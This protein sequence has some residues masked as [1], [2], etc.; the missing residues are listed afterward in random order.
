MRTLLSTPNHSFNSV[1]R[2]VDDEYHDFQLL[3]NHSPNLLDRKCHTPIARH[4]NCPPL[5]PIHLLPRDIHTKRRSG[6]IPNTSVVHLSL[7]PDIGGKSDIVDTEG[8]GASFAN[9]NVAGAE[10][11]LD[12]RP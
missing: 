1:P 3:L 8:C 6:S 11:G 4:Q 2:V 7:E 10:E 5:L 12:L 9:E